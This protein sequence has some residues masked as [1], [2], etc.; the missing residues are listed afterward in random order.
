MD[1]NS[2]LELQMTQ[3]AV[4]AYKESETFKHDQIANQEMTASLNAFFEA[5]RS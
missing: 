1:K 2:E 3:K 5:L 4:D